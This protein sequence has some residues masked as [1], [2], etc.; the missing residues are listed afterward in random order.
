MTKYDNPV[1]ST[2][3]LAGKILLL[4]V[5][6][7]VC[8]AVGARVAGMGGSSEAENTAGVRSP[9]ESGA[10][11]RAESTGVAD[12]D[13]TETTNPASS[14]GSQRAPS[15]R[16]MVSLL[17]VCIA[18]TLVIAF[19]VIRSRW[20]GL[21]LVAAVALV[22][23]GSMSVMSQIEA[24]VFL[25]MG[26][27]VRKSLIMG[28][29]IVAPFSF[30]AVL[31]L[32]RMRRGNAHPEVN[33]RLKLPLQEWIWKGAVGVFIYVVLYL[34]FGYFIAWQNPELR[35]LYGGREPRGFLALLQSSVMGWLVPLQCLRGALW[36]LLALPVIR[37][38]KGHWMEAALAVG[39]CF[40]VLMNSQLLIPNPIM[41]ESVRMTHLVETASSNF[42]FGLVIA[43]LFHR[44]HSHS[45][46]EP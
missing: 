27:L 5:L 32:G 31:V 36:I 15:A 17:V 21:Q 28:A 13:S 11:E 20:T 39:L 26:G 14:S 37:M 1:L 9:V 38:M 33:S 4:T 19:L 25:D 35:E 30:L 45:A 8:F 18:N 29:V 44:R 6:L 34:T 43:A 42:L 22:F 40:A 41:K 12:S 10:A 23:Y 7:F 16:I 2:F 46:R 24:A 3:F